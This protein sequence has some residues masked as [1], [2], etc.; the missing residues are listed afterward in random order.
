MQG[1][2]ASVILNGVLRPP[3]A[4]FMQARSARELPQRRDEVQSGVQACAVEGV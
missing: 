4:V 1:S 3:A 2:P